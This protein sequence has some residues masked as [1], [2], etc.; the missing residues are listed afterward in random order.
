[1]IGTVR[2]IRTGLLGAVAFA[3]ALLWAGSAWTG[4]PVEIPSLDA[5]FQGIEAIT[6]ELYR[7]SDPSG[8]SVVILHG[9]NGVNPIHADWANWYNARGIDVLVPDSF[10]PRGY[11]QVLFE[12]GDA[13]TSQQRAFDAAS[14]Y[15]YLAGARGYDPDRVFVHG[16]SI[17][18][19]AAIWSM[20]ADMREYV[21]FRFALLQY[22]ACTGRSLSFYAPLYVFQGSQDNFVNN[23]SCVDMAANAQG[24]P[25]E[26]TVY[27]GHH[28]FDSADTSRRTFG[29]HVCQGDPTARARNRSD[30]GRILSR[31]LRSE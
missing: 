21:S 6:A 11:D 28:C 25:V 17:G 27:D 16:F 10:N 5:D 13:V 7:S 8:A 23:Q 2:A 31:S 20:I 12:H 30:V 15:S 22:P 14:A 9:S 24:A 3:S 19:M 4:E 29:K 26:V 1:L 18:G